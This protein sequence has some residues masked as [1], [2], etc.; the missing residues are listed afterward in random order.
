MSYQ[1]PPDAGTVTNLLASYQSGDQQAL[2]GIFRR[3][4]PELKRVARYL[5]A[6]ERNDHTLQTTALVNESFIRLF[7]GTPIPW[8][9]SRHFV[10]SAVG[11]MRRVLVDH[12]RKADAHKRGR[13]ETVQMPPEEQSVQQP[14]DPTLLIDLDLALTALGN[15]SERAATVMELSVFGELS[16]EEIAAV[17]G[18]SYRTVERELRWARAWIHRFYDTGGAK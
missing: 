10:A 1:V 3:V 4:L 18:V 13:R 7:D 15:T 8:K 14:N 5:L 11:E 2:D 12:A 6:A 16:S 17:L 9:N